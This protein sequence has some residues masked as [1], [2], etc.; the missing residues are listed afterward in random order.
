MIEK[1]NLRLY[2]NKLYEN[3][4]AGDYFIIDLNIRIADLGSALLFVSEL[5]GLLMK[6]TPT[7][8]QSVSSP[9]CPE[10]SLSLSDEVLKHAPYLSDHDKP[11]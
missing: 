9:T 7:G 3:E 11:F 8:G 6:Y 1:P 10:Q 5:N 4:A 2:S